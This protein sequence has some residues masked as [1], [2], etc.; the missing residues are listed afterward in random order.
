MTINHTRIGIIIAGGLLCGTLLRAQP[1]PPPNPL[2]A[3]SQQ[4]LQDQDISPRQANVRWEDF[5]GRN[6]NLTPVSGTGTVTP[7]ATYYSAS[8]GFYSFGNDGAVNFSTSTTDFSIGKISLQ[9]VQMANPDFWDEDTTHGN[10]EAI[11]FFDY[12]NQDHG[13]GEEGGY[14]HENT[15]PSDQYYNTALN[16]ISEGVADYAGGP[17]LRYVADGADGIY[18]GTVTGSILGNGYY[19]DLVKGMEGTYY[20]FLWEW[21]LSEIKGTITSISIDLPVPVHQSIIGASLTIGS[22]IPETASWA[23]TFGALVL[24]AVLLRRHLSRN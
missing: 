6:A 2:I 21:N 10:P 16:A 23:A 24:G 13:V 4:L 11:L 22:A 19:S 1:A 7:F 12:N 15:D 9:V 14:G 3:I 18:Q 20:N 8:Y 17:V 5:S